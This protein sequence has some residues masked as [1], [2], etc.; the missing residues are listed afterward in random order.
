MKVNLFQQAPYRFMPDGFEDRGIPSVVKPPYGEL[1]EPERMFDSYRWFMDELLAGVR[2]GYDGVAVTEHGQT[3]YDMTPNPN[4]PAAVLANA[5]RTESPETA[6][7]VLGRS[8]GKTREPLRIAEE[9]AMLDVMS[10]GRLVAGLP[11]GLSY[12][13]NLNNGIATVETRDRY[14]E[15]VELMM[16]SWA[17]D[18]P[19]TWNG[20]FSQY[21]LVNSWPRPLQRPRP[22]V[23]VPGSG[24]PGTMQWTIDQGY[25]FVYL[26]W[27]GPT[28]TA[29]RIFDRFWGLV[30]QSGIERNPY[31]V[32][33]VQNV[34]VAETDARA[35][36][37][38]GRYVENAF[39]QG[40]GSVPG[41][42]LG[43]P[44]Y[45]DPRGIETLLRDPGDLGLAAELS[46][47]T[48]GR[49]AEAR[50]VIAGSPATVR[51]QIADFVKEFRIGNLLVMLQMGGMPHDLTMKNIHLF[52]EEV[53]P[54]LRP[55]WEDDG[56]ENTWWPTG[57][58]QQEGV[59]G[60]G[61]K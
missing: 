8:L 57:L 56:W 16:R 32:G 7:I 61:P 27:F 22:P 31:R 50:S 21:S 15:A 26:S 60:G 35:E 54:H 30:D 45:V 5:I 1:V 40:V 55:L 43:L 2:A 13:A 20:R 37:E 23:W 33:F 51:E 58:P 25:A 19:F 18:E 44:G 12:D 42:Y 28:L 9:Y 14:R 6:L 38:Y 46:H 48:F 47:A 11:V 52:A 53:L 59:A 29:R 3:S 36:I 39:R 41:H 17:E 34:V 10:G 4:L 24:S 49:L